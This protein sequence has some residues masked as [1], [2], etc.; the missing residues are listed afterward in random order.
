[1]PRQNDR[2]S[3]QSTSPDDPAVGFVAIDYSAT[4]Q[5]LQVYGRGIHC[6]VA[7]TLVVVG[8]DGSSASLVMNAGMTYPYA[9][10]QITRT[11]SSNFVGYVLL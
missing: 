4:D 5:V 2:M 7:G 3:G 6:N 11:G 1:M 9:I 10:K 8:T